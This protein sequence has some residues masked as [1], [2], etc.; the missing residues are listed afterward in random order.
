MTFATPVSPQSE[1]FLLNCF[2]YRIR[3]LDKDVTQATENFVA[4]NSRF[5]ESS[6]IALSYRRSKIFQR[7]TKSSAFYWDMRILGDYWNC[8]G[9]QR[10]YHHTINATLVYGLRVALTQLAEEGLP[11]SWARHAAAAARFKRGL[12]TRGLQ[13]YVEDRR[14]Q[15]STLV[16]IRLPAGVDGKVVAARAMERYKVEIS[17]GLGPTVGKILRVGMTSCRRSRPLRPRRRTEICRLSENIGGLLFCDLL[18][19]S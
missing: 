15:L 18:I 7:K 3:S 13:C 10:V 6:I 17:G 8:F 19:D 9:G 4:R 12:R 14:Y 1:S 11:A 5:F 2:S 16:S